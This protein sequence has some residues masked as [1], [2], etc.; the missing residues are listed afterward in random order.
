MRHPFHFNQ[1]V[2]AAVAFEGMRCEDEH[3][4]GQAERVDAHVLKMQKETHDPLY[5]DANDDATY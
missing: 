4:E 1:Q 3:A 2:F 5:N